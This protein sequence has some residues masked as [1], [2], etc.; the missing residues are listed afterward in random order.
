MFS[1]AG[2]ECLTRGVYTDL[3]Y[4][5]KGVGVARFTSNR[6]T[7]SCRRSVHNSRM[8]LI[9]SAFPGSSGLVRLLLVVSTTGETSTGDMIT[10]IPCFN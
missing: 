4:P 1:K 8:F 2:S 3:G 9:R 10:I 5:L 7:I 6:F